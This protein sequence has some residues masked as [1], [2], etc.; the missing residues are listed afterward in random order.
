VGTIE[1]LTVGQSLLPGSVLSSNF[2]LS[3]HSFRQFGTLD[4]ALP[5]TK[6]N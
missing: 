4:V 6:G 5:K 3:A 1:G 2:H